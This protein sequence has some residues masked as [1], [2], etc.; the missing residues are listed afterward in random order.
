M[1]I[2]TGQGMAGILL[3]L[4]DNQNQCTRRVLS[5][6]PAE[7]EKETATQIDVTEQNDS[8]VMNVYLSRSIAAGEDLSFEHNK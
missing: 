7:Q 1:Q 6:V 3:P 8:C 5:V 2:V 4:K